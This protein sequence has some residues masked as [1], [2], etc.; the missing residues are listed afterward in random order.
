MKASRV[1]VFLVVAACLA[2]G[3]FWWLN[4]RREGAVVEPKD[5]IVI[6]VGLDGF[7]SDYLEKYQPPVLSRLAKGGVTAEKMVGSF[8]TLTFPN[9]FTL[10]TG[11]RPQKHGIINNNMYDP[12]FDA[13]FALGSPAVADGRWWEGEPVWL[14]V[15]KHGMKSACMFWPGSEAEIGGRRPDEWRR[16]DGKVTAEERVRTVLDWLRRPKG[17]RPGLVTLYFH[18]ADSAGHKFGVDSAQVAE[19]VQVVDAALGQLVKG[20]D[21]LKLSHVVQLVCVSDHG[22][23]DLHPDR[24]IAMG[25][26]M[27]TEKVDI[28]FAGAVAG[29]RPKEGG[30]TAAAMVE[31]LRKEQKHF[32][33]YLKEEVP[34]R[35]HFR[36]HRRIPPVILIADEGWFFVK[37]P[38]MSEGLRNSFLKATHGFDPDLPSMGAAFVASGSAFQSGVRLAPF[39]NV[40]IYGLVCATLGIEPASNDGSGVLASQVLKP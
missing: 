28:D 33:V 14:T 7:R 32:Q 38:L 31:R 22:M 1:Y 23:T 20:I 6:L 11:L 19:A 30:E 36:D 25:S 18:E 2:F 24:T 9:F 10:A 37:R 17:E 39:E 15:Q 26:L 13:S 3:A 21:E 16:Y 4:E 8:P 40:E 34:E 27:D 35:L 29:V 12:V 5:R